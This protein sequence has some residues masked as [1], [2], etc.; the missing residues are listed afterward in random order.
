VR[1]INSASANTGATTLDVDGLG[2]VAIRKD[3]GSVD[4]DPGDLLASALV[5]VVHNGTVFR[6]A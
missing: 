1:F 4:L 6:R 3:D 2:A 5:T